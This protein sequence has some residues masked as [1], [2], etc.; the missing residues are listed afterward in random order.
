MDNIVC[1]SDVEH[2]QRTFLKRQKLIHKNLI[3]MIPTFRMYAMSFNDLDTCFLQFRRNDLNNESVVYHKTIKSIL[4]RNPNHS[5][6]E[7]LEYAGLKIF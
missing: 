3:L 2:S 6:H 4:G 7:C 5:N 1:T